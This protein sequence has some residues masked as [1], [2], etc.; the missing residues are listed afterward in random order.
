MQRRL[1]QLDPN[2]IADVVIQHVKGNY[3]GGQPRPQGPHQPRANTHQ[4]R[5]Q[6]QNIPP[7]GSIHSQPY[8]GKE[9]PPVPTK[10]VDGSFNIALVCGYC[11]N[12]G[13]DKYVCSKLHNKIRYQGGDP[14]Q[15]LRRPQNNPGNQ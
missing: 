4:P 12:P 3:Q 6:G 9:G 15:E 5:P 13:H 14:W 2:S 8:L 1:Q 10:G 7:R 11:K